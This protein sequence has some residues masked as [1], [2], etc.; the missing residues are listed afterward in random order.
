LFKES[1]VF[2]IFAKKSKL[3]AAWMPYPQKHWTLL[4]KIVDRI[5]NSLELRVVLQTAVDE[6][7]TLL[8]LDRCCF[9]WYFED[10]QRVQ[11]VVERSRHNRKNAQL[12]YYPVESLG[13]IAPAIAT[14]KLIINSKT[15]VSNPGV[16]GIVSR[17]LSQ[18]RLIQPQIKKDQRSPQLPIFRVRS[19]T[20]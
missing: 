14:G 2:P 20:Y 18:L 9:L 3:L 15:A 16:V 10:T 19:L 6:I 11:V 8:N 12:G 1:F 7:A 13:V 4:Q 5:R 17:W